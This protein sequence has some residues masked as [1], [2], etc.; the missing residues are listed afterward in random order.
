MAL[1][2]HKISIYAAKVGD[3]D[4]SQVV[5]LAFVRFGWHGC[6]LRCALKLNSWWCYP[7]LK[8]LVPRQGRQN[9]LKS[10][11]SPLPSNLIM[12]VKLCHKSSRSHHHFHRW[13]KLTIPSHGLKHIRLP[14]GT[15]ARPK[16]WTPSVPIILNQ[17]DFEKCLS[18]YLSVYLYIYIHI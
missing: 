13:Y 5:R 14:H 1:G 15:N 11:S 17:L 2:C 7:I 8:T 3:L 6:G 16:G 4:T 10:Q 18:I 12:W 9:W